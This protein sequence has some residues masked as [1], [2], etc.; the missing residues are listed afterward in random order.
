MSSAKEIS[1]VACGAFL[2]SKRKVVGHSVI[3]RPFLLFEICNAC[4]IDRTNL[5][6][7]P[8]VVGWYDALRICTIPLLLMNG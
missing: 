5:S 6:A 1:V 4:L 8:L 2:Y 3:Q 7:N